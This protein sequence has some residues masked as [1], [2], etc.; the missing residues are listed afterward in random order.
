M[1]FDPSTVPS[2][3]PKAQ[4]H[5]SKLVSHRA[6]LNIVKEKLPHYDIVTLHSVFVFGRNLLQ[7]TAEELSG[8]SVKLLLSDNPPA[9]QLWGVHVDDV[10]Q[11][12]V[13]A[14]K[15]NGKGLQS[16]LLASE[17][18]LW[19]DVARFV[20]QQY[21]SFPLGLKPEDTDTVGYIVDASKAE[22]IGSSLQGDGT[23][24]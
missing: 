12:H 16:Y 7:E 18:W 1:S 11:A 8:S 17:G 23:T 13:K 19:E 15:N 20:K 2:L 6:T 9:G 3:D 5:A 10:A 21:P 4:Y 24:G 14:L 22:R